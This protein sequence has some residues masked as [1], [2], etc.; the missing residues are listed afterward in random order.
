[1]SAQ[2]NTSTPSRSEH[3]FQ[4]RIQM[5]MILAPESRCAGCG[6]QHDLETL[7]IDHRDGRTWD[8]SAINF[9]DRIRRI[10]R[11]YDTGVRLRALCRQCNAADAAR[12]RG[13][14]RYMS[15]AARRR[16]A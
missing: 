9:L 12:W 14:A 7:E 16:A 1:M 11:E 5:L 8:W 6:E 3:A 10:W 4:L 13:R 2:P 15:P